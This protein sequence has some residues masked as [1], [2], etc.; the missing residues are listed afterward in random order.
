MGFAGPIMLEDITSNIDL[1]HSV[2]EVQ[3]TVCNVWDA[4]MGSVIPMTAMAAPF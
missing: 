1:G 3:H 4:H 2:A